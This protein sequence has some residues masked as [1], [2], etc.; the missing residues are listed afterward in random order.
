[1]CHPGGTRGQPRPEGELRDSRNHP[2]IHPSLRCWCE[3]D[4]VTV[5][6]RVGNL[7]EGG[8]FLRT[9]TPLR[10]GARTMIRFKNGEAGEVAALATVI[11]TSDGSDDIP[12]GMGLRFESLDETSREMLQRLINEQWAT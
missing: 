9:N 5:Y 7:S 2:R 4:N 10:E 1:M 12:P 3:G 6:A 11:W 8:L